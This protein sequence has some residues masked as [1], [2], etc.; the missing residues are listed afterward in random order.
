MKSPPPQKTSDLHIRHN[1]RQPPSF[2]GD[3]VFLIQVEDTDD[4]PGDHSSTYKKT[5]TKPLLVAVSI[6]RGNR[7]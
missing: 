2:L 3:W 1:I 4:R 6:V 5:P 7:R